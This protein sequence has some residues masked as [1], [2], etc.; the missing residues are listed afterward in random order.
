MKTA[1]VITTIQR[2]THSLL[3]ISDYL[4]E[5]GEKLHVVGD[6]KSPPDFYFEYGNY[7]SPES[8]LT[9][10]WK[11]AHAV[12]WNSY[13]RKMVG[14]LVA[15]SE[16]CQYIRETDDDNSP[17]AGFF[18]LIPSDI[19][20]RIPNSRS[21]WLNPYSYFSETDIWPRGL[22][23]ENIA[24][25]PTGVSRSKIV[26]SKVGILQG[27]ANGSPDVDAIYRLTRG[28]ITDF[29]FEDRP[30]LLIPQ[31]CYTPFNSQATVWNVELL[32]LMYLPS[33]CSFRMTDIWRSF[34]ALR[35]MR[36][37]NYHLL[38]TKATMFQERNEHNLLKDFE[39]EVSGYLGNNKIVQEIER[40][41]FT[42]TESSF[43]EQL[44]RI[45]VQLIECGFIDA[46]EL[47]I[48]DAWIFDCNS[49]SGF[50]NLVGR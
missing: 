7:Y 12:P 45:Y 36:E 35:I 40:V 26:R 8:Q 17:L 46:T 4:R 24:D 33:T 50:S 27:L 3:Q 28:D 30:P 19:E 13:S 5:I 25:K 14:Y 43:S 49:I 44:K 34:I 48:L 21:T 20:V 39:S 31:S 9:L 29:E 2:P 18:D 10:P 47:K 6:K 11:T 22:P 41:K 1:T 37:T 42:E 23:L 16:G 15:A 38:F 32:P